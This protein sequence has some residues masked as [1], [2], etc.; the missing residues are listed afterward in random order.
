MQQAA[1]E[2]KYEPIKM[3]LKQKGQPEQLIQKSIAI[4]NK[5]AKK[6]LKV[7]LKTYEAIS[8]LSTGRAHRVRRKA[9]QGV[10]CPGDPKYKQSCHT[11]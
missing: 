3:P 10:D 11:F 5:V 9:K 8:E 6:P 4:E 1:K 2:K 7:S